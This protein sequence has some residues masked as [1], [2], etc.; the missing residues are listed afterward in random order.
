MDTH[1]L[2]I[3]PEYFKELMNG[4]K[5]FEIRRHD[6][7]F[8]V[9]DMLKLRE[10]EE[11]MKSYT[12]KEST[13]MITYILTSENFEGLASGYSALGIDVISQFI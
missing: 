10:W 1:E 6:R 2:K 13:A 12:S 5:Y 9:G 3:W 7:D 4:K 8:K 11:S